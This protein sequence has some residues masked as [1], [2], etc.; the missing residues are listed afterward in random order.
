MKILFFKEG[1]LMSKKK[2]IFIL[3]RFSMKKERVL[4]I[5]SWMNNSI[6]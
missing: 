5:Y 4:D 6:K 1:K 2:K 3:E